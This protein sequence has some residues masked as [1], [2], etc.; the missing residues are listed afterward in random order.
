MIGNIVR[1]ICF[2][3][4]EEHRTKLREQRQQSTKVGR[5]SGE[6]KPSSRSRDSSGSMVG[7]ANS[8]S[9]GDGEEDDELDIEVT[10]LMSSVMDSVSWLRSEVRGHETPAP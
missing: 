7:Q 5:P 6:A 2:I 3:I 9:L 4:R 1:R 8:D 10:G